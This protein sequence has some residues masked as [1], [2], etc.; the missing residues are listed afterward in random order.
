MD[1]VKDGGGL[2]YELGQGV[3][4]ALL[5]VFLCAIPVGLTGVYLARRFA[6]GHTP[7]MLH[8]LARFAVSLL[9]LNGCMVLP[10][11]IALSFV[12]EGRENW[13]ILVGLIASC[14]ADVFGVHAWLALLRRTTSTRV[15]S[16]LAE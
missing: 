3:G 1:L 4:L 12:P 2:L 15:L 5:T 10:L 6:A 16:P 8:A 7:S 11:T 9:T 14:L 13:P